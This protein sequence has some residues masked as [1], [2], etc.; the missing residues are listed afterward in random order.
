M[1]PRGADPVLI[2]LVEGVTG[3]VDMRMTLA[4]RFEYGQTVPRVRRHGGVPQLTGGAHSALAVQPAARWPAK[5][6]LVGPLLASAGGDQVPVAAV[7]RPA[8]RPAPD[9]PAGQRAGRADRALV[10]GLG[11]GRCDCG[12]EWRDAVIRSLITLKALSYAPTG[13]LL[14]APTTSL[15]QQPSGVRNW[16]YRYCWIRDA[17][18]GAGRVPGRRGRPGGQPAW[19][20]GSVTRRGRPGGP[21]RSRCTG[22]PGSGA[23]RSWTP[24]GCPV[25]RAPSR[26]GSATPRRPGPSSARSA[27]CCGP[28]WP[29]ARQACPACPGPAD[30][31][32]AALLPAG[33]LAA[34]RTPASGRCAGRPGTSCTARSMIWAAADAAVTMIEPFGDRGPVRP[35]AAAPRRGARRRAGPRLRPGAE[36]VHPAVRLRRG[37]RQPAPAAAA[38]LPAGRRPPGRRHRRGHRPGPGRQRRAAALPGPTGPPT[39]TACRR[40]RRATCPARSG[41]PAAARG[42]GPAAARAVFTRRCSAC[43]TTSG[44]WPRATT[45]CADGSRATIRWPAAHIEPDQHG[46]GAEPGDRREFARSG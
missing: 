46:P 16:D 26:C 44:C 2:R 35:L 15:P 13:G 14:A 6:A 30:P 9:R 17:R 33:P 25:T 18:R 38:R 45:R 29:P 43:A 42:G 32:D 11:G 28:G 12:G 1:P 23:S 10:A 20:T 27:T 34:N 7:W 21:G 3:R 39:P 22:W 24:T 19:W 37:G 40:A 41:W 5:A 31:A 4:P 8:H 36:H